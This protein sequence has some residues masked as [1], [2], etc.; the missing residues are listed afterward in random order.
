MARHQPEDKAIV[1]RIRKFTGDLEFTLAA[2]LDL[3]STTHDRAW[4]KPPISLEFQVPM[5]AASG[6]HVRFLKVYDKIGYQPQRWVR[7]ITRAGEY[8]IRF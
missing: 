5:F 3:V 4:S 2:E 6:I 1:W 7:Y 8:Q